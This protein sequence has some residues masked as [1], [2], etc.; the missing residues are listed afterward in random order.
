MLLAIV[1]GLIVMILGI[2]GLT[3]AIKAKG[4]YR[5]VVAFVLSIINTIL[6]L[7]AIFAVISVLLIVQLGD[8]PPNYSVPPD[9]ESDTSAVTG[10]SV[11]CTR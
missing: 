5:Y 4:D 1:M 10:C 7:L 9:T 3:L 11:Y 2:I 6:G 8:P